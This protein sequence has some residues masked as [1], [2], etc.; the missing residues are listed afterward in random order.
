V[1]FR[2]KFHYVSI[3]AQKDPEQKWYDLP[4]L[5]T[6]DEIAA[7]IES[8]PAEWRMASDL[9]TGSSKSAV[10]QKKEEARI[11]MQQL[12]ERRK[13][14]VE[15]KAKAECATKKLTEEEEEE[16]EHDSDRSQRSPS[17]QTKEDEQLS[18]Q[19][20]AYLETTPF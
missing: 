8:W 15:E 14:E 1:E 10:K 20:G 16:E 19:G 2:E 5:E 17:S 7:V 3:K 6:D 18:R 4:Y 9:S 12:D 13:K 11:K